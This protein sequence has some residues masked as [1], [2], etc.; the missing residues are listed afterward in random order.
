MKNVALDGTPVLQLDVDGADSAFHPA[1]DRD[2]LRK[3]TA[4]DLCAIADQKIR[5]PQLA[6]DSTE[7]L[8][9]TIA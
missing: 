4:L 3:D 8:R 1:T 9:W 2:L 6:F 5:G 7:D